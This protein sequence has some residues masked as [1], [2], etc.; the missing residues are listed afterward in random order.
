MVGGE[1]AAPVAVMVS[2][3]VGHETVVVAGIP[4]M[5][6]SADEPPPAAVLLLLA[7]VQLRRRPPPLP[8]SRVGDFTSNTDVSLSMSD[9]T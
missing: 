3:D 2:V 4:A 5:L 8:F 7:L 6:H 1:D 9:S